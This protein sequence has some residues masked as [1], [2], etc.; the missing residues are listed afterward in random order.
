M[1][2]LIGLD[3]SAAKKAVRTFLL[4]KSASANQIEFPN[5]VADHLT[6]HSTVAPGR[7]Y[8]SP[9]QDITPQGRDGLF[10]RMELDELIRDLEPM[11]ENGDRGMSFWNGRLEKN[12]K[13]TSVSRDRKE[14]GLM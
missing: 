14:E 5:L 6:K 11:R 12:V 10:S 7:F 13:D 2:S 4:G 3:C 1:R 8:G 9:F